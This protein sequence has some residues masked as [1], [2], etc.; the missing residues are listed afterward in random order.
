MEIS[1]KPERKK[2]AVCTKTGQGLL[3]KSPRYEKLTPVFLC[4]DC[5]CQAKNAEKRLRKSEKE[6]MKPD[7]TLAG[8]GT[9]EKMKGGEN[10]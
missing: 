8:N 6:E 1:I 2:C 5:L 3:L 7:I 4:F 10:K 9:P